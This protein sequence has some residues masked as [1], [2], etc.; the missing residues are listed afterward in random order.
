MSEENGNK[1]SGKWIE[2]TRNKN[3]N[4]PKSDDNKANISIIFWIKT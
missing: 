2:K 3:K 1:K 4:I